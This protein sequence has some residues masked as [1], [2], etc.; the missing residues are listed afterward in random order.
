MSQDHQVFLLKLTGVKGIKIT[1]WAYLD[2]K[3]TKMVYIY[4]I[5]ITYALGCCSFSHLFS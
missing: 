3:E 1:E 2:S 4:I 5:M